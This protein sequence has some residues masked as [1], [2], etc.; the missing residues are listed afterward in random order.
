MKRFQLELDNASTLT[1]ARDAL[2]NLFCQKIEAIMKVPA[3][4]V[5]VCVP[6]S[7]LGLDSMLAVEFRTWLIQDLHQDLHINIPV[8]GTTGLDSIA[9]LCVVASRQRLP[10]VQD[11]TKHETHLGMFAPPFDTAVVKAPE[12]IS[13]LV[14]ARRLSDLL[15]LQRRGASTPSKRYAG[16]LQHILDSHTCRLPLMMTSLPLSWTWPAEIGDL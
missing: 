13:V 8:M 2:K 15:F 1:A 9:S 4:I 3:S 10:D 11:E 12:L 14:S 5:D 6:L 7:D 16:L